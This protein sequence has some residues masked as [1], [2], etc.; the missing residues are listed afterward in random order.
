MASLVEFFV[1]NRN[2]TDTCLRF[3][4]LN[5]S[6]QSAYKNIAKMIEYFKKVGIKRGDVVTLAVQTYLKTYVRFLLLML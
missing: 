3:N 6:Y 1:H 4:N 2:N 5:I